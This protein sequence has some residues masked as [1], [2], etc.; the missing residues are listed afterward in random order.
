MMENDYKQNE[1]YTLTQIESVVN[2]IIK[3][4]S[5]FLKMTDEEFNEKCSKYN[6]Q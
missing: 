1:A 6:F 5:K 2:L 4:N 3:I